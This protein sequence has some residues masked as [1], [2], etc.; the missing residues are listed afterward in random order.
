[1]LPPPY[2]GEEN[3]RIKNKKNVRSTDAIAALLREA[4]PTY[5][6]TAPHIAKLRRRPE[7]AHGGGASTA[8]P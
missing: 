5:A 7:Q 2:D 8:S 4:A 6:V 1:M 3:T